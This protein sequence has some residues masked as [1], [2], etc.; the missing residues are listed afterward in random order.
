MH[1]VGFVSVDHVL[2]AFRGDHHVL[3]VTQQWPDTPFLRAVVVRLS[4]RPVEYFLQIAWKHCVLDREELLNTVFPVWP[5]PGTNQT[6]SW[7]LKDMIAAVKAGSYTPPDVA[8]V[9]ALAADMKS[10]P[11][12]KLGPL[13]GYQCR[14]RIHLED[15]TNRVTAAGIADVIP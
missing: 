2:Q 12:K 14:N 6:H 10:N 11:T 1:L 5:K 4:G 3:N 8:K 13:V 15:G 7:L 9:Q